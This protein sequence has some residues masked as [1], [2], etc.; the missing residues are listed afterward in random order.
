M[1]TM[2]REMLTFYALAFTPVF[3]ATVLSPLY[4]SIM[5]DLN[6]STVQLG[7]IVS[8]G[9]VTT[10]LASPMAGILGD[11]WGVQAIMRPLLAIYVLGTLIAGLNYFLLLPA[12]LTLLLGRALQGCGEIGGLQQAI[13]LVAR[14]TT[15]DKRG[16]YMSR[17]EAFASAGAA[18]GP[19]IGGLLAQIGWWAGYFFPATLMAI[20]IL[21][22]PSSLKTSTLKPVRTRPPSF[23]PTKS[24]VAA[25]LSSGALMLGLSGMQTFIVG[26]LTTRFGLSPM[27]GGVYVSSHALI[28]SLSAFVCSR[29]INADRAFKFVG[30]GLGG[31]ALTL[32]SLPFIMSPGITMIVMMLGGVCCGLILPSSNLMGTSSV[33][34]ELSSRATST[35][36]VLR[37]SGSMIGSVAFGWLL[38]WGYTGMFMM[39]GGVLLIAAVILPL[40]MA[41]ERMALQK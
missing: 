37:L 9:S 36:Y 27:E 4:P 22:F 28:M 41:S 14:N 32:L 26:Y 18:I 21:T 30:V 25:G 40:V 1:K 29:W 10:L 6:L 31:F 39:G 23:R 5:A 24:V 34:I 13:S 16:R 7:M 20:I 19:L 8:F 15:S 11:K 3:G 33:P 38:Q 12:F 2:N 35:I 17:I